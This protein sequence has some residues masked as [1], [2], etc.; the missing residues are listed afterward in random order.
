MFLKTISVRF[1]DIYFVKN[2]INGIS[3]VK[4]GNFVEIIQN[5]VIFGPKLRHMSKFLENCQIIF[6]LKVSKN[7]LSQ[8]Y[9]HIFGQKCH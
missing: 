1:I 7:D 6:S 5:C 2:V 4:I 8:V 9:G 3:L